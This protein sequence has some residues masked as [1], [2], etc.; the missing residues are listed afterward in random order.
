MDSIG[1]PTANLSGE[2]AWTACLRAGKLELMHPRI[3]W[4]AL[5]QAA[6][7]GAT[8]NSATSVDHADHPHITA[9]RIYIALQLRLRREGPRT[10]KV[11]TPEEIDRLLRS[12]PDGWAATLE[13]LLG[14]AARQDRRGPTLCVPYPVGQG[15]AHP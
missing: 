2:Q 6:R 3:L 15:T 5:E 4:R 11:L 9:V 10:L 13:D 1:A 8:R 7:I 12:L 14:H